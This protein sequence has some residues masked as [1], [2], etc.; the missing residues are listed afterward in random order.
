[1]TIQDVVCVYLKYFNTCRCPFNLLHPRTVYIIQGLY[2][3]VFMY[4]T[5]SDNSTDNF[6][7]FDHNNLLTCGVMILLLNSTGL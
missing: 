7:H 3:E 1:M 4:Q 5:C 2:K 6:L